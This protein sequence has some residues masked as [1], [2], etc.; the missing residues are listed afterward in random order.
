MHEV[1]KLWLGAAYIAASLAFAYFASCGRGIGPR[2]KPKL[3]ALLPPLVV[4]DRGQPALGGLQV[5]ALAPR[6]VLDLVLSIRPTPK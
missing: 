1:M 3:A 5:P 4:Q 6:I 2:D